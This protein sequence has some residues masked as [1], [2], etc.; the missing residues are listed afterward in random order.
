M[1]GHCHSLGL[2]PI[3][4]QGPHRSCKIFK[5]LCPAPLQ[6]WKLHEHRAHSSVFHSQSSAGLGKWVLG[7]GFATS[8]DIFSSKVLVQFAYMCGAVLGA[9]VAKRLAPWGFVFRGQG[10]AI[11]FDCVL[12][13]HVY[14]TVGTQ[15]MKVA[16]RGIASNNSK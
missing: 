12:W 7:A 16:Q 9:S 6:T 14:S 8:L 1:Q 3:G 4:A 13:Y 11:L 2:D 5:G 15:K 10:G